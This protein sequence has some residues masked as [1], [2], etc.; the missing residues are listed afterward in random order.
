MSLEQN[1]R[2][3]SDLFTDF[4][5]Q[6]CSKAYSPLVVMQEVLRWTGKQ[7]FLSQHL[8]KLI[9]LHPESFADG[10]E[11]AIVERIV[12][13][14]IIQNWENNTASIYLKEVIRTIL[15]NEQR[16]EILNVYLQIL[17]GSQ[18]TLNRS[19]EQKK[20]IQSGLVKEDNETLKVS[21]AI[22]ASV[23]SLEWFQRQLP[24]IIAQYRLNTFPAEVDNQTIF[25]TKLWSQITLV[26]AV[27][28]LI[29]VYTSL[30]SVNDIA[31]PAQELFDN[32]IEEAKSARWLPMLRNFCRISEDSDYF[33]SAQR[34]LRLWKQSHEEDIQ[35]ALDTFWLAESDSCPVAEDMFD[36]PQTKG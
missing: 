28:T 9:L 33:A 3:L 11:E 15:D 4:L 21:N 18:V 34:Q 25:F 2:E 6:V 30:S 36:F 10:Q 22:Y 17:Q 19:Q 35:I 16:D 32:G 5:N 7:P 14:K 26:A 23:F 24:D 27:V 8:C 20:L 13:E 1:S 31:S 29:I 12:Q